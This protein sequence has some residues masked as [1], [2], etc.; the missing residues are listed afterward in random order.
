[1]LRLFKTLSLCPLGRDLTS[2]MP[3]PAP[4]LFLAATSPPALLSFLIR[5]TAFRCGCRFHAFMSRRFLFSGGASAPAHHGS[6]TFEPPRSG[7]CLS[8]SLSRSHPLARSLALFGLALL[9][10]GAHDTNAYPTSSPPTA[11]SNRTLLVTLCNAAYFPGAV[12]LL[13][14]AKS[15]GAFHGDLAVIVTEDVTPC[16][17]TALR[18]LGAAVHP[19]SSDWVGRTYPTHD[20]Q[21]SRGQT[22]VHFAKLALVTDPIFRAYDTVLY[23]DSDMAARAPLSVFFA[24]LP[25][26][27]PVSFVRVGDRTATLYREAGGSVPVAVQQAFPDRPRVHSTRLI[28]VRPALLPSVADITARATTLLNTHLAYF[29]ANFEQGLLQL[30]FYSDVGDISPETT[31]AAFDHYYKEN[32]PWLP[33]S[34]EFPSFA[35]RLR[36]ATGEEGA[37]CWR[38]AVVGTH[39][40][41]SVS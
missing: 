33:H 6:Q 20:Q 12:N 37:A 26:T 25:V 32:L 19:A 27:A 7:P 5:V 13:S 24:A 1:M 31:R 14:S 29:E 40:L 35:L 22:T 11:L 34:P 30:L 10:M 8:L 16:M 23:A 15:S 4:V 18:A 36:H 39:A 2:K 38:P 3:T 17:R 28:A 41:D 21:H 9:A